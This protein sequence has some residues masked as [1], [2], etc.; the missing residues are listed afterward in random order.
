MRQIVAVSLMA[1][2]VLSFGQTTTK[3]AP[4]ASANSND[5]QKSKECANQAE[6]VMADNDRRAAEMGL[7]GSA[8]W[9]NHYS[10]KY[11]KCF[12]SAEHINKDGGVG[13]D[14]PMFAT[15]LID[16]FERSFLATSASVGPTEG[17]C[18]IDHKPVA[19]AKAE[20]FIADRMK[21]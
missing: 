1:A 3:K 8:G 18:Q 9:T 19:C 20:T 7:P 15:S 6:K 4:A 12:I 5:W 2:S 13:K 16:A 21:N 17:F 14:G 11:D 10:P